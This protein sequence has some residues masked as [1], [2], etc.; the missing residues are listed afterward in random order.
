M[1]VDGVVQ[2]G[3][4]FAVGL[5]GGAIAKSLLEAGANVRARTDYSTGALHLAASEGN[6]DL[7]NNLYDKGSFFVA[8][9]ARFAL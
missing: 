4:A 8:Q 7:V 1:G 2:R 6:L 5:E 9:H 3:T